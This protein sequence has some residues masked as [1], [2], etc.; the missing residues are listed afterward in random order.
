MSSDLNK[1]IAE[2]EQQLH[3]AHEVRN[4]I[5]DSMESCPEYLG[6]AE[7]AESVEIVT[8][9]KEN[10]ERLN[11]AKQEL[12]KTLEEHRAAAD[13]IEALTEAV[14]AAVDV[15][16]SKEG[17]LTQTM[18]AIEVL[19]AKLRDA[20]NGLALIQNE[21]ALAQANEEYTGGLQ[22]RIDGVTEEVKAISADIEEATERK[23]GCEREA[24]SA[25]KAR[26]QAEMK[27]AE[28]SNMAERII[29]LEYKLME[30]EE[31]IQEETNKL[32][33]HR[34]RCNEL[35]EEL[36]STMSAFNSDEHEVEQLNVQITSLESELS[37]ARAKLDEL[38]VEEAKLSDDMLTAL[39][40]LDQCTT[41]DEIKA[42]EES[43]NKIGLTLQQTTTGN[44]ILCRCADNKVVTE[45]VIDDF[46][47]IG[48][49]R[50]HEGIINKIKY[51]MAENEGAPCNPSHELILIY[52]ED[53]KLSLDHLVEAER[54]I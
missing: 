25:L 11:E 10:L 39:D 37:E 22:R 13:T 23:Y 12:L 49:K 1:R 21:F 44:T 38:M 27:L 33:S 50:L 9:T 40:N 32:D 4:N 16:T 31:V 45:N 34:E 19:E 42:L 2:L 41:F 28:V 8:A 51:F 24:F 36:N 15:A 46:I 47:F 3:E 54:S 17:N 18:M 29:P 53:K 26:Q 20:E 7:L 14:A 6:N 52:N 48:G 30:L 5:L 43:F 35:Q